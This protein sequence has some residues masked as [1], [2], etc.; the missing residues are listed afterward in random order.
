IFVRE[1][2]ARRR[3]I[4]MDNR[5]MGAAKAPDG[6]ISIGQMAQDAIGL[7]ETLGIAKAD[8]LGWSMGGIIAQE[9]ARA[10]PDLVA[11]LTLCATMAESAQ[12]MPRLDRMAG[13]SLGELQQAMFPKTWADAH[14]EVFARLPARTRPPDL[15]VIG[16][17]YA[18]L[19]QWRGSQ[20]DLPN[21]RCPVL[22]LGGTEDWISPPDNLRSMARAIPGAR[23]E[24][25]P[26]AG[27]WMMHQY[28]LHMARLVN[29]FLAQ[30]AAAELPPAAWGLRPPD[31]PLAWA[32]ASMS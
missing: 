25:L 30:A 14:P 1:L 7:L 3:V 8:V 22:L 19:K 2:A 12:L 5:G 20:R 26:E 17:Q 21:L 6:P 31:P 18:A 10:R 32:S 24:L 23:L 4:L 28:P 9:M 16:R 27:H 13:M 15:D 29:A 11:T